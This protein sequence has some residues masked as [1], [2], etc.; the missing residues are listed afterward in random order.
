MMDAVRLGGQG[1][2]TMYIWFFSVLKVWW[3]Q[4]NKSGW[5]LNPTPLKNDGL[6]PLGWWHSIPNCFWKVIKIHGSKTPTRRDIYIYII[7]ICMVY[8]PLKSPLTIFISCYIYIKWGYIINS[9]RF[10]VGFVVDGDP[11]FFT[12][13]GSQLGSVT[14]HSWTVVACRWRK[15]SCLPPKAQIA[16]WTLSSD[17]ELVGYGVFQKK[18][19]R[20]FMGHINHESDRGYP[21]LMSK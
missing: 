16:P 18:K 1:C 20:Y 8:K 13:C 4:K 17:P 10:R 9:P 12:S 6:R 5:W 3:I 2:E 15:S 11:V 7:C 19:Q 21:L 14:R